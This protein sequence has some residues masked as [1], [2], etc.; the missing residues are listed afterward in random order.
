MTSFTGALNLR[1]MG[2]CGA[3]DSLV[4]LDSFLRSTVVCVTLGDM[5]YVQAALVCVRGHPGSNSIGCAALT[6]PPLFKNPRFQLLSIHYPWIEAF[7][8]G[9]T[10]RAPHVMPLRRGWRK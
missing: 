5:D 10:W 3:D 6:L 1:A 4:S 7:C 2:F 9:L 8:S